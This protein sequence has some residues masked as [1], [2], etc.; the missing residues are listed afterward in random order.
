MLNIIVGSLQPM[1]LAHALLLFQLLGCRLQ[2]VHARSVGVPASPAIV[3]DYTAT[4]AATVATLTTTCD[5]MQHN[6]LELCACD[7]VLICSE[8]YS[9]GREQL[10]ELTSPDTL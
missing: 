7:M 8:A 10:T 3:P 6:M 9:E 5:W 4:A 1:S 2:N